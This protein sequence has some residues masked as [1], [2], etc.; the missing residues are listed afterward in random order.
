M[1]KIIFTNCSAIS[2]IS[3]IN[4]TFFHEIH[5]RNS[6]YRRARQNK[7]VS[8]FKKYLKL[9][10]CISRKLTFWRPSPDRTLLKSFSRHPSRLDDACQKGLSRL[11]LMRNLLF[12]SALKFQAHRGNKKNDEK[13]GNK[14]MYKLM[15]ETKALK[16]H[17]NKVLLPC[18]RTQSC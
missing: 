17:D 2:K 16:W 5:S 15:R 10:W 18:E 9:N 4:K 1:L 8:S 14:I 11:D 13:L 7:N 6:F 12:L 3:K